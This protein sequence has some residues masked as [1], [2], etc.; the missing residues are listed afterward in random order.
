MKNPIKQRPVHDKTVV[1]T[2]ASSGAGR[3]TALVFAGQRATLILAGRRTKL[4]EE[5][6]E[7]CEELGARA[8][9][10]TVDVTDY[11][12]VKNLA[13]EAITFSGRIDVW[14]NNAGVLAA[15]P[16]DQMPIEIH[17]RVVDINLMGYIN[18]AHAVLPYFKQQGY[19][20]LINNI[21]V[22]A[23]IATPYAAAYTASKFGLLG[24]ANALRGELRNDKHIY[25][26]NLFPAFL[27]TPGIQ[28]AANYTGKVLRPAPPVYS[29]QR[30]ANAMLRLST[31][32]QNSTTTDLAAP[33]LKAAYSLAPALTV[34]IAAGVMQRYFKNAYPIPSTSGNV[35]SPV[36]YGS[37]VSGGWQTLLLQKALPAIGKA[38]IILASLSVGLLLLGK[39]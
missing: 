35:L 10:V 14:I 9:A 4:L 6:V 19:G 20:V 13:H 33:F 29:P 16:F 21:S 38:A 28:H 31:R 1:I 18:G 17:R 7:E 27:D 25:V 22:G 36:R 5:L 3:A 8:L 37:S 2:G 32:P 11:N 30:V 15:G 12:A 23:W 24:F 26:C 39:R 34:D